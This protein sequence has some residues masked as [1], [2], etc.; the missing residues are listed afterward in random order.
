[1]RVDYGEMLLSRNQYEHRVA[2]NSIDLVV[3]T[4]YQLA[5]KLV[6]FQH[7]ALVGSLHGIGGV[8]QLI[9]KEVVAPYVV[10][11]YLAGRFSVRRDNVN[12]QDP[13]MVRLV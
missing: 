2:G 3:L 5:V 8:A 12:G 1:M 4:D 7:I 10:S 9:P 6:D 13:S 11:R